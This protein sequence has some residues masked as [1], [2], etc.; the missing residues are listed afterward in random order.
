MEE[1]KEN[2][3]KEITLNWLN[4]STIPKFELVRPLLYNLFVVETGPACTLIT[5]YYVIGRGEKCNDPFLRDHGEQAA[6]CRENIPNFGNCAK[7]LR[8]MRNKLVHN[9]FISSTL[10][11]DT[12][13]A[14]L[15]FSKRRDRNSCALDMLINH[16][17]TICTIITFENNDDVPICCPLCR[18]PLLNNSTNFEEVIKVN[19]LKNISKDEIL[20][21]THIIENFDPTTSYTLQQFKENGYKDKLKGA[22][23]K[24]LD[25]NWANHEGIFKCWSGTVAYVDLIEGRKVIRVST[26]IQIIQ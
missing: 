25:G 8:Q 16:L 17:Y 1:N 3:L 11:R 23:I 5:H 6:W 12:I 26:L 22:K 24:I 14:T 19:S 7:R 18:S 9:D 2:A 15:E 10:F 13:T 4:S 20:E 21:N